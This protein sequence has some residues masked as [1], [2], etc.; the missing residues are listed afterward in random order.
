MKT[1]IRP[2]HRALAAALER[3]VLE[4]PGETPPDVRR[5]A[6]QRAA[7]GAAA[8]GPCDDVARQIGESAHGVTDAQVARVLAA[9]GS[10]KAA[11]E[12]ITAAAVGAGLM[13]WRQAMK[14][15]EETT[16]APA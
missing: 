6:A 3:R 10:E 14:V 13:R 12:I 16:D 9:T 8:G 4:G 5:A 2:D 7:G 1:P 15:L 11:F